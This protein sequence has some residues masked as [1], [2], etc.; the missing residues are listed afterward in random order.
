MITNK[1]DRRNFI[2]KTGIGTAALFIAP[3]FLNATSVFKESGEMSVNSMTGLTPISVIDNACMIAF[4][5]GN[6]SK[7]SQTVLS[8]DIH[9]RNTP[10]N[11]GRLAV[12]MPPN[13]PEIFQLI[14]TIKNNPNTPHSK[15]KRALAFG[16]VAINAVDKNIN[17]IIKQKKGSEFLNARFHQDALIVQGFSA[18][19]YQLE[20]ADRQDID[21]L[22]NA[23]LV[24]TIT[25]VHTLKPD[26]DD[27]I[28][29]VNRMSLWRKNNK[30]NMGKF[31]AALT[32]PEKSIAGDNFFD[33]DDDIVSA[34]NALQKGKQIEKGELLALLDQ[35]STCSYGEAIREATRNIMS[36]EAYFQDRVSLNEL[37]GKLLQ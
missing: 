18:P 34:T 28:G 30:T 14:H 6:M 20:G 7:E 12:V 22:L 32:S 35:T 29:W 4:C 33:I 10:G 11:K 21:D 31:A 5:S 3:A 8:T 2:Q 17:S 37:E 15:E 27:G 36:I 24:R 25:R 19:E 1:I 23:I 13:K 9:L 16:W 26:S